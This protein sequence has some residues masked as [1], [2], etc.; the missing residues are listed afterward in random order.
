MR[1]ELRDELRVEMQDGVR[2][3]RPGAMN[4]LF[5]GHL[6]NSSRTDASRF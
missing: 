6:A 5:D 1:D 2:D 3:D 4:E